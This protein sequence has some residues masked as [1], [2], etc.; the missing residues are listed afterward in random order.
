MHALNAA[1]ANVSFVEIETDKGHDAFLLDE[2][3]ISRH[4]AR[5][6]RR[7]RRASRPDA[8]W[9]A[10]MSRARP[11]DRGRRRNFPPAPLAT[12]RGDLRLVAEMI[13]PGS[14]VLDIG[15]GDGELLS[16]LVRDKA[17]DGRGMEL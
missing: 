14:R 16:Y 5:L 12:L 9:R 15:C 7:L 4:L 3:E 1:P 10:S 8:V 13:E 2:P 6:P 11:A 17:V